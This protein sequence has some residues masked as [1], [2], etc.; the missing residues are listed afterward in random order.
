MTTINHASVGDLLQDQGDPVRSTEAILT[1][2]V[3]DADD[4]N[5]RFYDDR[6]DTTLPTRPLR[7]N[8][9]YSPPGALN[10]AL[11]YTSPAVRLNSPF[12]PQQ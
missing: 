6:Y 10:T 8:M 3:I 9:L 1:V 4:Q 5:P 11:N 7:V 2:N 12:K